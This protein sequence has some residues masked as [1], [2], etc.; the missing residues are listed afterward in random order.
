MHRAN[1]YVGFYFEYPWILKFC[2][3]NVASQHS[4]VEGDEEYKGISE[5]RVTEDG[6]LRGVGKIL[7]MLL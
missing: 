4:G 2:H 1:K 3:F 6:V 5:D 7:V